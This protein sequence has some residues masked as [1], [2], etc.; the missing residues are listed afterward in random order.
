MT[1]LYM[2]FGSHRNVYVGLKNH[3]D[4]SLL[5]TQWSPFNNPIQFSMLAGYHT[6]LGLVCRSIIEFLFYFLFICAK[7]FFSAHINTLTHIYDML[8]AIET[9]IYRNLMEIFIMIFFIFLF[10]R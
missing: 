8:Y 6:W 7:E 2:V 3:I 5:A 1:N 4:G 10:Y 9:R